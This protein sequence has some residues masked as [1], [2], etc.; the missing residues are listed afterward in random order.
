MQP[1]ERAKLLYWKHLN[2]SCGDGGGG[3][4]LKGSFKFKEDEF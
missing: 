4:H 1:T 2:Y 3:R